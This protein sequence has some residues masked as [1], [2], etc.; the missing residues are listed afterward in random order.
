M[1]RG[2]LEKDDKTARKQAEKIRQL[3]KLDEL[4]QRGLGVEE[5]MAK[6]LSGEMKVLKV[7]LKA[8]TKGSLEAIKQE[9]AKIK[10]EEV[11]ISVIH[12]GVGHITE[13]DVVM[14][15]ASKGLVVGFH[16]KENAQVKRVAEKEHVEVLNYTVIYKLTEDLTKLL[17]GLLEPEI[18]TVELGKFEVLKIFLTKKDEMIVGG[19]VIEGKLEGKGRLRVIRGEENIGE[20]EIVGLKHVNQEVKEM[21]KGNECGLK[22]KGLIKLQEGDIL[23]GYKEEKRIKTL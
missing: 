11:A 3:Q 17:S 10:S 16:V 18:I 20:G 8:D 21:E 19:K 13:T 9:L 14:A 4:K 7:I 12:S 6:I 15:S 1:A 5:I 22:F 2:G 23:E